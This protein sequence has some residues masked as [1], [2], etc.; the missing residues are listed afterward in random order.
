MTTLLSTTSFMDYKLTDL[1][2]RT[3]RALDAINRTTA[4]LKEEEIT[5]NSDLKKV[6]VTLSAKIERIGINMTTLLSTTS[7]MDYK[8]TDLEKRT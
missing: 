2:K 5:L 6:N 8:L 3:T 1:E 7:F 4:R